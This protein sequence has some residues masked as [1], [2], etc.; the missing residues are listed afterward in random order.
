MAIW[1]D[2]FDEL[3]ADLERAVPAPATPDFDMPPPMDEHCFF[4]EWVLT[5]D[6]AKKTQLAEDPR[7]KRVQAYYD[8]YAARVATTRQSGDSGE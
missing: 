6:P 2:P 1:R 4:M 5:E 8:R 3:I 7:V